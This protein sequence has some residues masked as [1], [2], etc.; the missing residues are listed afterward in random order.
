MCVKARKVVR[1][2]VVLGSTSTEYTCVYDGSSV[3][4]VCTK[5]HICMYVATYVCHVYMIP[6]HVS[7]QVPSR[8]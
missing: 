6:V 8:R 4:C 7:L 2:K 3:G 5:V 1:E